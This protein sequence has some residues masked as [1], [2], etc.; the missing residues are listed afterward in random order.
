MAEL[1]TELMPI[2]KEIIHN[3]IR[4]CLNECIDLGY[5]PEQTVKWLF[6]YIHEEYSN[7]RENSFANFVVGVCIAEKQKDT[8]GE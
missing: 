6:E 1:F 2:E 8:E 5:S 3:N 4:Q 7:E